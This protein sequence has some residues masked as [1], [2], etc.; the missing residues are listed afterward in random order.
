VF[1]CEECSDLAVGFELCEDLWAPVPP[2]VG[3]AA[4]GAV[5]IGNL[6]ASNDIVGKSE[7]RRQLVTMQSGKLVCGYL[8][9]S[10][11]TGESTSDAVYGAHQMIAE[12]GALLAERRY[13]GGLLISEIDVQR[14]AYERRRTQLLE[15]TMP[16]ATFCVEFSLPL[17]KTKG[18][19]CF[20]LSAVYRQNSRT[21]NLCYISGTVQCQRHN[22]RY[23]AACID[24]SENRKSWNYNP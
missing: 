13:E 23:K 1:R 5:V 22:T 15:E 20:H 14:L 4:A 9:A 12:N 3:L 16:D 10:S 6:S 24:K 2:S 21:E 8:Y 19:R 18:A 17:R 11:G 7:Y